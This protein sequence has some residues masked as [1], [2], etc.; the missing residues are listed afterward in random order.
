MCMN[1]QPLFVQ[2]SFVASQAGQ[3]ATVNYSSL[4]DVLYPCMTT[5]LNYQMY[6]LR[7]EASW[8]D[9]RSGISLT[10]SYACV[11]CVL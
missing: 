2:L 1:N 8:V 7:D 5:S 11:V 4:H 6:G 9:H 10:S 3:M